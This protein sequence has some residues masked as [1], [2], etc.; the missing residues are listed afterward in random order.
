MVPN[1]SD[2]LLLLPEVFIVLTLIGVIVGELG[3]RGERVRVGWMIIVLGL[4]GALLQTAL[5]ARFGVASAFYN[6]VRM[7]GLAVF[8]KVLAI[9]LAL[10]TV[11]SVLFSAEIASHRRSEFLV[12]VLGGAL[13][14]CILASARDLFLIF[15]SLQLLG[16]SCG[17]LAAFGTGS[18]RSTE[19]AVKYL[20]LSLVSG[21]FLLFGVAVLFKVTHGTQLDLIHEALRLNEQTFAFN[22]T[23]WLFLFMGVSFHLAAFPFHTWFPDTLEGAPAPAAAFVAVASR[24]GGAVALIRVVTDVFGMNGESAAASDRAWNVLG[25]FH[26]PDALAVVAGVTL[27][28]GPLLAMAQNGARR[29][30]AGVVLSE[31]GFYLIGVLV[32]DRT[33]L[34]ALIYSLFI[35][36]FAVLGSFFVIQV[37]TDR[38]GTDSLEGLR[39][40][41]RSSIPES[42]ALVLFLCAMIGLP[43]MPGFV[44]KFSLLGAAVEHEWYVLAIAGVAAMAINALAAARLIFGL[45]GH[46]VAEVMS[47]A[48]AAT[49]QS[50]PSVRAGEWG[51]RLY[52]GLLLSPLVVAGVFSN[53]LFRLFEMAVRNLPLH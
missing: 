26:W 34:A 52:I 14:L 12:L 39:G 23:V 43:P 11:G 47:P 29:L 44:G 46:Y 24:A 13:A 9:L 15:V 27:L 17:F 33:G 6:T 2:F 7:D 10:Y 42:I 48:A 3:Y 25:L 30:L 45:M 41:F 20:V 16:A 19:A 32:L 18:V 37:L 50:A 28:V 36:L 8:L 22:A 53:S 35:S 49:N 4:L 38:L 31:V 5:V 21:A 1:M 51:I 40:A